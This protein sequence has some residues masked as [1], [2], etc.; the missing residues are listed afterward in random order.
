M[1]FFFLGVITKE[2]LLGN[3]TDEHGLIARWRAG[4]AD[5]MVKEIKKAQALV[6]N[7]DVT[8]EEFLNQMYPPIG[9][10]YTWANLR[11]QADLENFEDAFIKHIFTER[12]DPGIERC[13]EFMEDFPTFGQEIQE[14]T[15]NVA[16]WRQNRTFT[17]ASQIETVIEKTDFSEQSIHDH[18]ALLSV[19]ENIPLDNITILNSHFFSKKH[20]FNLFHQKNIILKTLTINNCSEITQ[21]DIIWMSKHCKLASYDQPI[22]LIIKNC[23]QLPP[24][25]TQYSHKNQFIIEVESS[26]NI[27]VLLKELMAWVNSLDCKLPSSLKNTLLKLDPTKCTTKIFDEIADLFPGLVSELDQGNINSLKQAFAKYNTAVSS[28]GFGSVKFLAFLISF[29]GEGMCSNQ[30]SSTDFCS[31]SLLVFLLGLYEDP[32]MTD[33]IPLP[34]GHAKPDQVPSFSETRPGK[35]EQF[36]MA[37]RQRLVED[38]SHMP[39]TSR[40]STQRTHI[41]SQTFNTQVLSWCPLF[42]FFYLWLW[43]NGS[44]KS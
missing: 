32:K 8:F 33:C 17:C 1:F 3:G 34:D 10:M 16:F 4:S 28:I 12:G 43:F 30:S 42:Q 21:Q 26:R 19:I 38:P 22:K 9:K 15:T 6:K 13:K 18:M 31:S 14:F 23:D 39:W 44:I 41:T 7:V 36:T 24:E 37:P 20:L 2:Q 11:I 27:V 29:L 35:R 5:R 40:K 25:I